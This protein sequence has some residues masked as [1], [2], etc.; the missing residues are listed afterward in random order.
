MEVLYIV[1]MCRR[2]S[3]SVWQ[4]IA[5]LVKLGYAAEDIVSN[6]FRVGKA[7]EADEALR[8]ALLREAGRAHLRVAA[9]LASPLQL[10]ALLARACRAAA[11][12]HAHDDDDW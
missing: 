4:V 11:H 3:V 5:K 7:L 1:M 12:A 8:L 2:W 6:V 10:A 9:G